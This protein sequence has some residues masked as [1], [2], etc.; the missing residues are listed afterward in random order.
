[1]TSSVFQKIPCCSLPKPEKP[2]L[3]FYVIEI[4]DIVQMK[5]NTNKTQLGLIRISVYIHMCL[6][7][8]P[9]GKG[10]GLVV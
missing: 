10:K 8:H 5:K 6:L 2:Q 4:S 9:E 7:A 3:T 1:M